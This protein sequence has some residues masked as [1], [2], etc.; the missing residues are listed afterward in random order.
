MQLGIIGGEINAGVLSE[1][2]AAICEEL[3]VVLALRLI[4][5]SL[6]RPLGLVRVLRVPEHCSQLPEH[7]PGVVGFDGGF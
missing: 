3:L 7:P 1:V 2:E 6:G 5:F 4:S